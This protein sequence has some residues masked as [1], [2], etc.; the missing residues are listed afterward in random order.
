MADQTMTPAEPTT[1]DV[2]LQID[3][4][5]TRVEDDLRAGIAAVAV[6]IEEVRTELG[7]RIDQTRTELSARIDEL[8]AKIDSG[9]RWMVGL[10]LAAWITTIGTML[11]K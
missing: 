5:L 10:I 1:R 3:R 9:F 2:L 8:N 4:R 7:A 6:R 11:L